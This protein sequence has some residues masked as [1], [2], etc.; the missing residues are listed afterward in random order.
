MMLANYGPTLTV[1]F[2]FC[3][4][5]VLLPIPEHHGAELNVEAGTAAVFNRGSAEP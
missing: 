2:A 1:S 5:S 3:F 4:L